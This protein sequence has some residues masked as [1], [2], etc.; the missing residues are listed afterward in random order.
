[1]MGHGLAE[2]GRQDE[3][4]QLRLVADFGK[5]DDAGGYQECV[6]NGSSVESEQGRRL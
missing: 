5:G 3:R 6:Q 2:L 4:Q 1:M